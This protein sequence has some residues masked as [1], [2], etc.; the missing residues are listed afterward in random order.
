MNL[1][2]DL[3]ITLVPP[4][5]QC[6]L[7]ISEITNDNRATVIWCSVCTPCQQSCH[8]IILEFE[9]LEVHLMGLGELALLTHTSKIPIALTP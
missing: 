9:L 6:N 2:V 1:T 7:E 3:D 4:Q 8:E 5:R